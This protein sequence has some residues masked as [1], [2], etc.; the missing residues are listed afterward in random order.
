MEGEHEKSRDQTEG[1]GQQQPLGQQNEQ[2]PQGQQSQQQP[3]GQRQGQQPF[4]Q[5]GN[6][7]TQEPDLGN[8][9]DQLN[10]S[11]PDETTVDNGIDPASE[12]AVNGM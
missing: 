6:F 1:S 12:E 4:G 9:A 7:G 3:Q 5:Q 11:A 8:Q 2:Q 10:N